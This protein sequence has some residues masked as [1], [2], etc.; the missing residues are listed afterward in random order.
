MIIANHIRSDGVDELL[1]N[2]GVVVHL[3]LCFAERP[4]VHNSEA[5]QRNP[6]VAKLLYGYA[7]GFV[8]ETFIYP[9]DT[10]RRSPP[11]REP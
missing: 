2:L 4:R 8:S 6:T 5:V 1:E 11:P 10:V 9:L 7:A 3:A